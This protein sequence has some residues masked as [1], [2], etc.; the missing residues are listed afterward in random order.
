MEVYPTLEKGKMPEP[1]EK[2]TENGSIPK[3]LYEKHIE[4]YASKEMMADINRLIAFTYFL[5]ANVTGACVIIPYRGYVPNKDMYSSIGNLH[6]KLAK[7][8]AFPSKLQ[9][10]RLLRF[11]NEDVPQQY[12]TTEQFYVYC[13][14]V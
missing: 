8:T 5:G 14:K 1:H 6:W 2:D 10:V 9:P 13:A 3:H 7:Q 12:C 4:L 11:D